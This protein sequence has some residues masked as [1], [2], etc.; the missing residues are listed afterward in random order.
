[1]TGKEFAKIRE[2]VEC[3]GFFNA[4]FSYDDYFWV[5]DAEFHRLKQ[6]M[7]DAA[8]QLAKYCGVTI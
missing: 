8:N 3:E 5:E 1:M 2:D 7:I 4:F 6:T